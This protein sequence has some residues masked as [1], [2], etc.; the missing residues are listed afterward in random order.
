MEGDRRVNDIKI[1]RLEEGM[2]EIR[3]DVK[4]VKEV[5]LP[6]VNNTLTRLETSMKIYGGLIMAGITV[7]IALGVTP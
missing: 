6:K 2:R 3:V 7:L 1:K 5:D 4:E